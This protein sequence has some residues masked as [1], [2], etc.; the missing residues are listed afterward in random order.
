M[1]KNKKPKSE[2]L[3]YSPYCK[4]CGNCGEEG[5]CSHIGCFSNLIKNPECEYGKTYVKEAILNHE[6][7]KMV[8]NLIEILEKDQNYSK[9]QFIEDFRSEYSKLLDVRYSL[10]KD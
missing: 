9:E 10:N 5:C 1:V 8:F 7:N 2:E 3:E 4:L 6:T